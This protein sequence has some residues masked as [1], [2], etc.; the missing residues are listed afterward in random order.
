MTSK[1]IKLI[2]GLIFIKSLA[3]MFLTPIFQVPDE[4]SHFSMVQYIAETGQ[5]PY[6]RPAK[7]P[8]S[9]QELFQ[10]SNII[11][12]NWQIIHP[13]W[14]G[15][16][17]NW[18]QAISNISL[19]EKNNFQPN[20]YQKS[21]KSPPLYYWLAAPSYLLFKTQ[22]FLYRFISV[23]I[24]SVIFSL[25]TIYLSFLISRQFFKSKLLALA[26]ASLV[27][28]QPLFSFINIGVHYDSLAILAT[29]LFTYLCL[30]YLKSKKTKYLKLS[31]LIAVISLFIKP[32]LAAL[33]LVFIFLLNKKYKKIIVT[34]LIGLVIG[35]SSSVNLIKWFVNQ[36]SPIFDKLFYLTNLGEYAYLARFVVRSFTS[37]EFVNKIA[38][39][40]KTIVPTHLAQIFPW[41][42]G[43]FGWLEKTMPS[44]IYTILKII[45]FVSLIGLL[46]KLLRKIDRKT[47]FLILLILIH[48]SGILFHDIK[49][50]AGSGHNFGIQGR[51]LLPTISSHMVLLV[52]GLSQFIKKKFHSHLAIS[53]I[54]F[55]IFLNLIGLYSAYQ[56]FGWVW[57]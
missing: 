25:L 30:L 57:S 45:V 16:Q 37:I 49:V 48:F 38:L 54:I 5:R 11:N 9:S 19:K 53:L 29:T 23:R 36:Q 1:L 24:L 21:I 46:K 32:D 51:Y 6:P 35:L 15:Y 3:W 47:V 4:P 50:F 42:W 39:Y 55:S 22:P 43:V 41:Y 13:V 8:P 18:R 40:F 10:V 44:F 33:L 31:L 34:A 28:F 20:L 26:V 12:F 7:G 56:Y 27:A 14:Q 52:L 17:S 2:I